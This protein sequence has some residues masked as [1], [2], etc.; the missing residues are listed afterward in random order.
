M[1]AAPA[2]LLLCLALAAAAGCGGDDGAAR[3]SGWKELA[4]APLARTEVAAARVGRHIYVIGGFERD[5]GATTAAI[6]RYD[7]ESGRWVRVPDMPVALNHA[8]AAAYRGDVY[9]LG[10]YRGERDLSREVATLYRYDPDRSRWSRLPSAPTA[11]A[12][13]AVGVIGH[14]LYAAGGANARGGALA[15]LEIYDF[16][17]RR[18]RTGPDMAVPR[19]HLAGAVEGGR[20]YALAGRAA[21]RG[22]F[23]VVEA[24]DPAA[25]R[26]RR[27]P[28]MGKARGGIGAA[29]VGRRIVVVGGEE[30][31]G[32]IR[33]VELFDPAFVAGAVC[34]T[35]RPRGTGSGSSR[36]AAA[37][38]R[39]RAAT[40]PASRSPQRSRCSTPGAAR[41]AVQISSTGHLRAHSTV[42]QSCR[43]VS[44]SS[45][46]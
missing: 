29:T 17:S 15:T 22:N 31:G 23:R 16:R 9:V 33:E 41:R 19:E 27:V 35:S 21:G 39:S 10:G 42:I 20:F 6:E 4:P 25:R 14:R 36:A 2:R 5:S 30:E 43:F 8:A 44:A 1:R 13:L 7:I 34:P 40:G 18:W 3:G 11:R 24:F 37:S 38:T 45:G 26:W 32:T 28:S 46:A 12:A